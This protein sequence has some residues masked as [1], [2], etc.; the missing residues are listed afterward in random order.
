MLQGLGSV[1]QFGWP[2]GLAE[3]AWTALLSDSPFLDTWIATNSQRL[4][5]N[6]RRATAILDSHD[7]D[8]HT[9]GFRPSPSPHTPSGGERANA[10]RRTAALFLWVDLSPFLPEGY[11]GVAAERE[12]GRRLLDAGVF[13]PA[14]EEFCAETVGHFRVVFSMP[15]DWVQE[16]LARMLAVCG[17]L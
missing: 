8:C 15:W 7:I 4:G 12:L 5:E 14:G 13:M 10:Q 17:V 1:S 3:R 9:K 2:S 6:Y 16:G 11:V